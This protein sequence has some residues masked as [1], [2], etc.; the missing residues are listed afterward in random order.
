[1][2]PAVE[3]PTKAEAPQAQASIK[4][5]PSSANSHTQLAATEK[6][7]DLTNCACVSSRGHVNLVVINSAKV[8]HMAISGLQA[9]IGRIPHLY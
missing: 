9:A 4:Q 3:P 2:D 6:R 1:M 8:L 7:R 5:T